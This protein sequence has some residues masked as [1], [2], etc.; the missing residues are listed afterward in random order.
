MYCKLSVSPLW[1]SDGLI[2]SNWCSDAFSEEKQF[3]SFYQLVLT[4]Q[5]SSRL[6]VFQ[7]LSGVK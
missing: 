7:K 4:S 1:Y 6:E 3:V 2:L 5:P